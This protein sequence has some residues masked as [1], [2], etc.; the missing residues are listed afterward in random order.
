MSQNEKIA[1]TEQDQLEEFFVSE[2]ERLQLVDGFGTDAD[3]AYS[4]SVDIDELLIVLVGDEEYALP[5]VAIQ[6]IIKVPI[7][8]DVPRTPAFILGVVSL[9]GTIVPIVDLRRILGLPPTEVK[10]A[11]RILVVHSDAEPVGFLVDQV[12]TVARLHKDNI[13]PVPR[14]MQRDIGGFLSGVGRIGERMLILFELNALLAA[15]EV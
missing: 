10:R 1:V 7:I 5:I 6:E 13:E 3:S 15:V 4:L 9:R 14:T 8:T 12:A 11:S 2:E